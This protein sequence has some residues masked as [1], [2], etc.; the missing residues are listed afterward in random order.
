VSQ[1][2]TEARKQGQE[3]EQDPDAKRELETEEGNPT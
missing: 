3:R 2:R 1:E